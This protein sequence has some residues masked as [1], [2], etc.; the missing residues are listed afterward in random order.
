MKRILLPLVALTMASSAF[1]IGGNRI[2]HSAEDR[3]VTFEGTLIDYD[4][5]S[6][7]VTVRI[8][9]GALSKFPLKKLDESD[10]E[11]ILEN[12]DAIAAGQNLRCVFEEWKN[13]SDTTE[14]GGVRTTVRKGG[15]DVKIRNWSDQPIDDVTV[16]T[17]VYVRRDA[18]RG[19]SLIQTEV[20]E[21]VIEQIDGQETKVLKSVEVPL[22]RVLKR[23][24][25][26]C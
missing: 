25:A 2:F 11:F 4:K 14:R 12:A 13:G 24:Q 8:K 22:E 10:R 3:S 15:F 1:A 7:I 23:G 6:E 20:S 21:H 18:E 19:P 5:A 16:R 17:T 9:G 26:G